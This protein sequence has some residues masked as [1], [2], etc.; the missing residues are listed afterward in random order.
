MYEGV[1]P[2]VGGDLEADDER[3]REGGQTATTEASR[4]TATTSGCKK[5]S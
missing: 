5:P 2:V 3:R 1:Q 4:M